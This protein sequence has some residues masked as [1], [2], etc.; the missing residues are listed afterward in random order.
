[1]DA[2]MD[3]LNEFM[4]KMVGDLGAAADT[5]LIRTGD[6]LGLY[7]AFSPHRPHRSC[8][9]LSPI[10]QLTRGSL[11]AAGTTRRSG[12][13][14]AT[15]ITSLVWIASRNFSRFL[16]GTTNEPGPPMTQSS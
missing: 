12:M 5:A 6:R 3:R 16:I 13:R 7:K 10:M 8:Q 4:G 1:M 15:S 14:P 2:N 9:I 11:V